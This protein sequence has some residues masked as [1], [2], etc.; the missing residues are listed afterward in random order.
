[1]IIHGVPREHLKGLSKKPPVTIRVNT[2]KITKDELVKKLE[3]KGFV[4]SEHPLHEQALIVNEQ[5]FSI[6]ATTEYLLGYYM[7]Q[8]AASMLAVSELKPKAHEHVL[9]MAAGPGAKT[10]HIC[11]LMKNKGVVV[12]CD[13]NKK[14]LLSV[15]YNA[16]RMG[17]ENIIGLNIDARK[18]KELDLE[19]D[20]ILL[21]APCSALGTL[22][23]NPELKNKTIPVKRLRKLQIGLIE[24][25]IKVL[26]SK[27]TLVYSTCTV[28]LQENEEI[29]KH[30]LNQG[31]KLQELSVKAGLP[32]LEG[33]ESARR[34]YPCLTDT[35]GFFIAKMVKV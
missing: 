18:I 13:T 33:L 4:L 6:G 22:Y 16:Q 3:R 17:C 31:M 26:K 25:A 32:G 28:T 11:E 5:P 15:K 8:D 23:K 21:D 12:A 20:K 30:A 7:L 24:T 14:R 2:L 9:D 1:M 27:G 10:T 19:F 35:Q 29:V 34:F